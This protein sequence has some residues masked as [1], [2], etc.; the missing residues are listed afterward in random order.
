MSIGSYS[1]INMRCTA[2]N[3]YLPHWLFALTRDPIVA[4]D[5]YHGRCSSCRNTPQLRVSYRTTTSPRV[6]SDGERDLRV[7]TDHGAVISLSDKL[8]SEKNT[9]GQTR[10]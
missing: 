1:I 8:A 3:H 2:N 10:L 9:G 6:P 5:L 4:Y 7:S